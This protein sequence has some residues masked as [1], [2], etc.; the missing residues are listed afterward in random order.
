MFWAMAFIAR[1]R[2]DS[3]VVDSGANLFTSAI[4]DV[5]INSVDFNATVDGVS[6]LQNFKGTAFG[7]LLS[8]GGTQHILGS[9]VQASKIVVGS[10]GQQ[11]YPLALRCGQRSSSLLA[12]C[13][14][15]RVWP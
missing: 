6:V 7:T 5:T 4:Q 1:I 2:T 13:T 3:Q 15:P 8:A 11:M 12:K 9:R 10:G 14:Y